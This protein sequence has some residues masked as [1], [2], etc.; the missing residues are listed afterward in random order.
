MLLPVRGALAGGGH[1]AGSHEAALSTAAANAAAEL[2]AH[3]APVDARM[4]A[5][6]AQHHSPAS[7][8]DTSSAPA[9]PCTVCTATCSTTSFLSEPLSVASPLAAA[10][11]PFPD[12]VAP[13]PSHATEGPERPPRSA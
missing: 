7:G 1:C 9:D 4:D 13:P 3:S 12:L 6:H 5:V 10:G 11:T 8:G 2:H